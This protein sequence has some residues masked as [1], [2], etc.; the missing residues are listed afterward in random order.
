MRKYLIYIGCKL[1]IKE[2]E[3]KNGVKCLHIL[4]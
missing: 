3:H 1:Y 4:I 2:H